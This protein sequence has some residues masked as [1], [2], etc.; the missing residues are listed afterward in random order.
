MKLIE[1]LDGLD[2]EVINGN[3]ETDIK[4]IKNDSRNVCEGICFSV[5]REQFRMDINTQRMY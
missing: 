2:F 4:D 1:L 5:Y 3:V